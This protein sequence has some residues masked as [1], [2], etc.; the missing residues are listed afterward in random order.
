MIVYER[1]SR[2]LSLEGAVKKQGRFVSAADL[3][4]IRDACIVSDKGKIF[5]VGKRTELPSTFK[6]AK[7]V[8]LDGRLVLPGFVDSHTHLVF[9]G[10]R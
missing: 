7:R 8:N 5:W 10:D 1:I 6:K 4:E 2:L 3:S 9:A